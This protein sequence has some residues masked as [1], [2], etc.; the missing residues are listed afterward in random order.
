MSDGLLGCGAELAASAEVPQA[1]ARLFAH[2]VLNLR[3]HARWV[4][5]DSR[6]ARAERDALL[7]VAADYE[8]LAAVAQG[9]AERMRAFVGLEPTRHD[10]TA[11]DAAQFRAWMLEKI[12]LQRSLAKLLLAHA[13]QSE[14]ALAAE[15]HT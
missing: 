11:F 9:T 2:V 6:A 5:G 4:D 8:D 1:V 7:E 13:F 14:R 3:S 12:A 10:A 15:P